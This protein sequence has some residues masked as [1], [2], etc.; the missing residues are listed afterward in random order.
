[1]F[2]K[3]NLFSGTC[4]NLRVSA[5]FMLEHVFQALKLNDEIKNSVRVDIIANKAIITVSI[6]DGWIIKLGKLSMIIWERSI[7]LMQAKKICIFQA[8]SFKVNI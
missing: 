7:R 1:M 3:Y 4:S 2:K 5:I 8:C 6:L